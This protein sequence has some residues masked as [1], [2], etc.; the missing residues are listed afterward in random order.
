[1]FGGSETAVALLTS[2]RGQSHEN[3]LS[4]AEMAA[5]REVVDRYAGSG[6]VLT[7]TIVHL[8]NGPGEIEALQAWRDELRPAGWKVYTLR[9]P[10]GD[11]ARLS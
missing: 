10:T 9:G 5:C 11:S 2:L 3:V 8:N 4:N 6:R 7:H 1:M